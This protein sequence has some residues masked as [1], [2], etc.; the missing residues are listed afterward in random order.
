VYVFLLILFSVV[1]TAGGQLLFKKGMSEV[2][3][4]SFALTK[5]V[6]TFTNLYVLIGF[7]SLGLGAVIWL[8][9]LARRDVSYAYPMSSLGYVIVVL[10]GA[11]LFGETIFL[12]RWIGIV[13][14]VMGVILLGLR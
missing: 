11:Y 3:E 2:G 6:S 9:V 14:I 1:L 13:L 10:A 12:N 5:L 8:D 7:L 4:L